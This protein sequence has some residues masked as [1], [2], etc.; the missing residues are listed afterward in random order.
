MACLVTNENDK[1]QLIINGQMI[2]MGYGMR[3][4]KNKIKE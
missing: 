3:E 2:N 1:F 4:Y